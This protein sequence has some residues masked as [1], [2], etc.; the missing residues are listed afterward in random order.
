M[1]ITSKPNLFKNTMA[2]A[3]IWA[4]A[5]ATVILADFAVGAYSVFV[6][7]ATVYLAGAF[8]TKVFYGTPVRDTLKAASYFA[9]GVFLVVFV[10]FSMVVMFAIFDSMPVVWLSAWIVMTLGT[11]LGDPWCINVKPPASL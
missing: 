5:I 2:Y 1:I 7:I 10:F 3:V 6:L 8:C 11:A 9:Y 4:I